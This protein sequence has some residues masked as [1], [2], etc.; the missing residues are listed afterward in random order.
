MVTDLFTGYIL[1]V[2]LLA[3]LAIVPKL[4]ENAYDFILIIYSYLSVWTPHCANKQVSHMAALV[5]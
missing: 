4:Y 5:V 2:I 3:A 1:Y